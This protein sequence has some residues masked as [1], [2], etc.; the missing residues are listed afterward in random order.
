MWQPGRKEKGRVPLPRT[1]L[2]TGYAPCGPSLL[3][4]HAPDCH[5]H[6]ACHHSGCQSI[7]PSK[8]PEHQIPSMKDSHL[9]DH[10]LAYPSRQYLHPVQEATETHCQV[11][12]VKGRNIRRSGYSH[13]LLHCVGTQCRGSRSLC[14]AFGVS[15]SCARGPRPR[16]SGGSH[17][18]ERWGQKGSSLSEVGPAFTAGDLQCVQRGETCTTHAPL[19]RTSWRC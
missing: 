1:E 8:G 9:M 10:L 2:H 18:R 4:L 3:H 11:P 13:S 6:G 19:M 5:I 7:P 16:A 14:A 12:L 15:T 17:F